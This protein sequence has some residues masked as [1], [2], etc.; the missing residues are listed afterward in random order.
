MRRVPSIVD[1]GWRAY[2]RDHTLLLFALLAFLV[3]GSLLLFSVIRQ[4]RKHQRPAAAT[5]GS[6]QELFDKKLREAG[7]VP[8]RE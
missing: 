3:F 8:P 2:L 6:F 4:G 5:S 1:T 7:K